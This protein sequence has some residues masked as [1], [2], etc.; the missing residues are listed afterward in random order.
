[1]CGGSLSLFF[2]VLSNWPDFVCQLAS[3]WLLG[4]ECT[5]GVKRSFKAAEALSS[6][7]AAASAMAL[8]HT[9][10]GFRPSRDLHH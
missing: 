3:T 9:L 5:R 7:N 4:T 8:V 2:C 1:M 10:C 6:D